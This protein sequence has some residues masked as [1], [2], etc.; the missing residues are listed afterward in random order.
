[1]RMGSLLE[2]KEVYKRFGAVEVLR[3]VSFALNGGTVLGLV[4]DNGAGKSTLMK[5]ITGVHSVDS[6]EI[7][8]NGQLLSSPR[9]THSPARA[10]RFGIEMVY[11]DLALAKQQG[12]AANIFLGRE[13]VRH[14]LGIL[15][16]VDREA[17]EIRAKSI[18]DELGIRISISQ[19]RAPVAWLS[20]GQQQTIA[21]A[22]GLSF[23]P[24]LLIL[25]EPTAALAVKETEHVLEVIRELRNRGIGIILISHRLPDIFEVTDRIL[26]LHQGK[27]A[28]DLVTKNTSMAEVVAHIVGA[29]PLHK[30]GLV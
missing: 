10:R 24:K 21:I 14:F 29:G 25:D 17:M 3:G 5:L 1:V 26:V 8:F 20:G 19:L 18:L 9:Q 6:G 22:R 12:V 28:A 30:G 16:I 15:P 7:W 11:Q 13:P 27:V 2:V 23:D 4:G